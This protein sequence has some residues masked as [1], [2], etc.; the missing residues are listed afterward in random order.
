MVSL[1]I[2]TQR[3][4]K[5]P[6]FTCL[7]YLISE[8]RK[9]IRQ[10]LNVLKCR[11][12]ITTTLTPDPQNTRETQE[13]DNTNILLP[14][15]AKVEQATPT[16]WVPLLGRQL[17]RTPPRDAGMSKFERAGQ[18]FTQPHPTHSVYELVFYTGDFSILTIAFSFDGDT[19]DP[20][21]AWDHDS[22]SPPRYVD[23]SHAEYANEWIDNMEAPVGYGSRWAAG[24][25]QQFSSPPTQPRR[26]VQGQG[27]DSAQYPGAASSSS[28]GPTSGQN[29]SS[30][31]SRSSKSRH[32]NKV[33]KRRT[34][35]NK[36]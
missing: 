25:E 24:N 30:S 29:S 34:K 10:L 4:I 18:Y 16:P 15:A 23:N 31:R 36:H 8:Y 26:D 32:G 19:T 7:C 2:Q 3:Q 12:I 1:P 14:R 22:T 21:T 13:A 17:K 28:S 33:V 35:D 6:F 27:I 9:K 5:R 20:A 11:T